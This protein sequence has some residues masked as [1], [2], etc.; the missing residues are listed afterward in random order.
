[1]KFRFWSSLVLGLVLAAAPPVVTLA[2]CLQ[3]AP[4]SCCCSKPCSPPVSPKPDSGCCEVSSGA[5]L[6]ITPPQATVSVG[7]EETA[8]A[9]DA[10][11]AASVEGLVAFDF[12]PAARSAP[13]GPPVELFTLHAAF[14]I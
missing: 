1:V 8:V 10:T 5:A 9:A 13:P 3:S 11:A 12:A 7:H 4:A 14:L 2:A 6:P